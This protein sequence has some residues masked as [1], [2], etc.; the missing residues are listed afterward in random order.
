LVL[1]FDLL[2]TENVTKIRKNINNQG[3]ISCETVFK[4]LKSKIILFFILSIIKANFLQSIAQ[5]IAIYD[6]TF[7]AARN[8]YSFYSS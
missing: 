5:L 3:K 4:I 6:Y 2:Q 1:N 7:L 8:L